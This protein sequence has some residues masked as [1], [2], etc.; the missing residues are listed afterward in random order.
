MN[1]FYSA[2]VLVICSV[3]FTLILARATISETSLEAR[4]TVTGTMLTM[5]TC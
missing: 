1:T 3:T 2:E 5:L 4:L